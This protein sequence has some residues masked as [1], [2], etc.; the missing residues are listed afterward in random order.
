MNTWT[1]PARQEFISL[2]IDFLKCNYIF[3]DYVEFGIYKGGTL[4]TAISI[5]A[6]H[7]I[8]TPKFNNM[9]FYGFD[10]FQGFPKL[11]NIDTYPQFSEGQRAYLKADVIKN[12]KDRG[13]SHLLPRIHL[14]EGWFEDTLSKPTEIKSNSVSFVYIDCDLY[15]STKTAL[16]FIFP[17]LINGAVIAFDDWFCFGGHPFK[18]EQK[19]FKEFIKEHEDI[20]FVEYH[21]FGWHGNSFIY[22]QL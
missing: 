18:G 5:I 4:S 16:N 1:S 3:G 8:T 11:T 19:A 20:H 17:K 13:F 14:I 22:H 12:L 2:I 21:K 9:H 15:E 7:Q 10:S 6:K